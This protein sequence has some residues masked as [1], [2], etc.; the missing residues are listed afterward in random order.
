MTHMLDTAGGP[1]LMGVVNAT[2]DSFSDGGVHDPVA[3]GRRLASQGAQILDVGGESTRPGAAPVAPEAEIARVAPVITGLRGAAP[4]LSIDTRHA[5]TM[6]AALEAGANMVNDVSALA[7]P[8]ALPLLAAR[9]DVPV[10]LMHMRGEPGTMQDAPEYG[11][12]VAEVCAF[13]AGR[14]AACEAAGIARERLLLDPGIGFGK[15]VAHNIAL[16]RGIGQIRA[17]GCPVLI[18]ASRKSMIAA[19]SRGEGPGARL[20]GSLA[21]ALHAARAGADVL[22]VHD[23]AETAQALSVARALF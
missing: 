5:A 17:L 20:P 16:L 19:L 18:G 1:L 22:R 2:P 12:V 14:I 11:D 6:R 21:I 15:T 4:W 9:P 8:A 10:C 23:V 3:H 7:D 13:L